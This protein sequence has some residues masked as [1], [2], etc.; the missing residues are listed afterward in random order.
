MLHLTYLYE[1]AQTMSLVS[2]SFWVLDGSHCG[3]L[4]K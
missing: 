2:F 1:Y 3:F 4:V